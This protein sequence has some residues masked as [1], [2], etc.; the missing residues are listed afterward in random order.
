MMLVKIRSYRLPKHREY[1]PAATIIMH[2]MGTENIFM[3]LTRSLVG[4]RR[5]ARGTAS[6][7]NLVPRKARGMVALARKLGE[8]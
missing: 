1:L 6:S 2:Y 4:T 8:S 5:L 7:S 3:G